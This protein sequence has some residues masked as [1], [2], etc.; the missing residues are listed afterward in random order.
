[1]FSDDPMVVVLVTFS[2][3]YQKINIAFTIHYYPLKFMNPFS[4]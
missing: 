2:P 4:F 3:A 1:M